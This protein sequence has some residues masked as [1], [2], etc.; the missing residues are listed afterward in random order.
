MDFG[1]TQH[2]SIKIFEHMKENLTGMCLFL[3][4]NFVETLVFKSCFVKIWIFLAALNLP[5]FTH[6]IYNTV[7][8][9]NN[10]SLN[11]MFKN[12]SETLN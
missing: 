11:Y 2:I 10:Q 5:A 8:L 1:S 3:I 12:M 7:N 6:W 4:T 9:S